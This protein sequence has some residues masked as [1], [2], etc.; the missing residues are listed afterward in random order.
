MQIPHF[1]LVIAEHH[2]VPSLQ[3]AEYTLF[4][5]L[6]LLRLHLCLGDHRFLFDD[7][8]AG[9]LDIDCRSRRLGGRDRRAG[10]GRCRGVVRRL[11]T[12]T[13]GIVVSGHLSVAVIPLG[14]L[15]PGHA[16]AVENFKFLES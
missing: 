7:G 10:L 4:H 8:W 3:D 16:E 14:K 12:G 5:D 13:R 15:P 1:A 2:R 11:M 9:G 6:P